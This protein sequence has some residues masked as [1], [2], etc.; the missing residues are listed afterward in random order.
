MAK[1]YNQV[2]PKVPKEVLYGFLAFVIVL[3]VL[4]LTTL[5][6]NQAK[7]FDMYS[8]TSATISEDHPFYELT[9][10]GG[11][12]SEGLKDKIEN[13]ETFILYIGSP[14]CPACVQTIGQ[15]ETFFSDLN[16][17]VSNVLDQ[18]F[19]YND[20]VGGP[21]SG[22]RNAFLEGVPSIVRTTPQLF[23]F[24]DG[25]IALTYTAPAQGGNVATN[26]RNF[27]LD[28]KNLLK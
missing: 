5:Q 6:S 20:F 9:Y 18:I 12:F 26:V 7:I 11:L 15:V 16:V 19:Y 22:D 25:E 13:K 17:G 10:N 8:T 23:L 28:A 1:A 3:I 2:K 27:F 4:F 21:A 14:F 24:V